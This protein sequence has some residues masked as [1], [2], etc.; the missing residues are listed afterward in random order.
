MGKRCIFRN[1][2]LV[3][4]ISQCWAKGSYSRHRLEFVLITWIVNFWERSKTFDGSIESSLQDNS[5]WEWPA[6][7]N[8]QSQPD[9]AHISLSLNFIYVIQWSQKLILA[10]SRA[11]EFKKLRRA[12]QGGCYLYPPPQE[13]SVE[14]TEKSRHML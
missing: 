9:L 6:F 10:L 7:V 13:R 14:S 5:F 3:K 8:L 11:N 1:F 2:R 4:V 12:I